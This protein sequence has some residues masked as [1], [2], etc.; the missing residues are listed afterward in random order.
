[1]AGSEIWLYTHVLDETSFSSSAKL[2]LDDFICWIVKT[3]GD[4]QG[5]QCDIAFSHL[6]VDA[7]YIR[8]KCLGANAQKS[9]TR[10]A[11]EYGEEIDYQ[12]EI[13]FISCTGYPQKSPKIAQSPNSS[14]WVGVSIYFCLS[15]QMQSVKTKWCLQPLLYFIEGDLTRTRKNANSSHVGIRF[16]FPS[17]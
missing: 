12:N 3:S 10:S 9:N 15:C 6:L 1:M 2:D 14:T 13:L 17:L 5:L 8:L 4:L 7:A 16:P 11:R